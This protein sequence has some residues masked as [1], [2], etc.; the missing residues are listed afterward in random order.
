MCVYTFSIKQA[1]LTVNA[2]KHNILNSFCNNG[3]VY[4]I[5]TTTKI[6]QT[7]RERERENT[8]MPLVTV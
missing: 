8:L 5:K 2:H 6:N 1:K 7:S 3:Y 4:D